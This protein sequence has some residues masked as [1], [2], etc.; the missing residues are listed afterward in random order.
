MRAVN[1]RIYSRT[2]VTLGVILKWRWICQREDSVRT[3]KYHIKTLD[4]T[5]TFKRQLV[6]ILNP[7]SE[8]RNH[9]HSK[10][11]FERTVRLKNCRFFH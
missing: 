9:E 2:C 3:Y 8:D 11:R 5:K 4:I 10:V 7:Q 6:M 1:E